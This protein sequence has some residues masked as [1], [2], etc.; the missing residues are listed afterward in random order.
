MKEDPIDPTTK[1]SFTLAIDGV[2][3]PFSVHMIPKL[4]VAYV[5]ALRA[6]YYAAVDD[7]RNPGC[8]ETVFYEEVRYAMR[9]REE[10]DDWIGNN[11]N[12]TS[13]AADEIGVALIPKP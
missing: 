8:F 12:L 3:L 10:I 5:A 11:M 7:G 2:P 1:G 9:H 6:E 4:L 13:E